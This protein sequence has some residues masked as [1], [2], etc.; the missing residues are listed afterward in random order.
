PVRAFSSGA[1]SMWSSWPCVDTIATRRR[2]PTAS[3]IAAASCAASMTIASSSS[4][5][6]HTL[7]S[8]SHVPPSSENVPDVST[9][10]IRAAI[11]A[12]PPASEH[13]HRPQDVTAVHLLERALHAVQLD[14]LGHERVE[15]E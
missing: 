13:H 14:R 6:I 5:T 11:R 3:A 10:S 4:P 8:T 2:P 7:L 15:V 12:S 1:A 9:W